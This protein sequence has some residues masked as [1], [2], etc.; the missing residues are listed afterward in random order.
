MKLNFC[1]RLMFLAVATLCF[2]TVATA[3]GKKFTLVLDAGHGGKDVGCKGTYLQEKDI[4]LRATL[5][6]GSLVKFNCPDVNVVYTRDNDVFI[7][8]HQRAN[9]AN[10][11]K[12]DLFISIH[13]NAGPNTSTAHGFETWTMGMRRS[14]E[15]LSA[16]KRENDV[17]LIEQDYEQHYAGYDPNSPESNIMFEFMLE[18][19]MDKSVELARGIQDRVCGVYGR[20]NRGVRQ[21]VFLVLRETSMPACLVELGFITNAEEQDLMA[22]DSTLAPTVRGIYEAFVKYKNKY[23]N[24]NTPISS[25]PSQ[26][27]KLTS[28]ASV[29]SQPVQQ[30][31]STP[32]KVSTPAS[33]KASTYI[34]KVQVLAS[35]TALP[36]SS[37]LLKGHTEA[38]AFQE[39]GMFKYTIGASSDYSEVVALRK[40]L[41][42]DFPEAFVIAFKDGKK[43]AV[44]EARQQQRK[45]K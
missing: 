11:A 9:I 10:K 26:P 33:Q 39:G 44:S 19:N 36:T 40:Q 2:V 38:E 42:A 28:V 6:L 23:T 3:A 30:A 15:K 22:S 16:A 45:Q 20:A 7:P 37:A 5:M 32:A 4:N 27:T 25:K 24:T 12:A 17:I 29:P 34:Y 13:T 21:D 18:K 1:K 35:S 41:L 31:K 43:I 14:D 8:L